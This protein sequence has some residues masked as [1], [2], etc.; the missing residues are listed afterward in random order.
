MRQPRVGM[1]PVV[2]LPKVDATGTA[3]PGTTVNAICPGWVL[4]PLVQS[5]LKARLRENRTTLSDEAAATITGAASSV[6]GGWVAH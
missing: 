4:T 2:E 6:D 3:N 5:R 1:V